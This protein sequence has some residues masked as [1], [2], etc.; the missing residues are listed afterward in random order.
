MRMH[1]WQWVY[2][3][4]IDLFDDVISL[5]LAVGVHADVLVNPIDKMVLKGPLDELM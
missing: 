4:A 1:E 5:I 2:I 3:P